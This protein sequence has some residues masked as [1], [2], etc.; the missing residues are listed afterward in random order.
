[1]PQPFSSSELSF[2]FLKLLPRIPQWNVPEVKGAQQQGDQLAVQHR[3]EKFTLGKQA[4]QA[5]EIAFREAKRST[6]AGDATYKLFQS[7]LLLII[8]L[9][10]C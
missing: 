6:A 1:M 7:S 3:I 10:S 9:K 4:Q 2:Q 8:E 5:L